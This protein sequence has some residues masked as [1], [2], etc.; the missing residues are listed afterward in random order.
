MNF[1][2]AVKRTSF[3]SR[4][5]LTAVLNQTELN[6]CPSSHCGFPKPR[7]GTRAPRSRKVTIETVLV[8]GY[9]SRTGCFGYRPSN[10]SPKL[11][12]AVSN[13]IAALTGGL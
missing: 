8:R 6:C 1:L 12:Q 9:K 10:P 7:T 3:S 2:K 13:R 5:P 11:G 4:F